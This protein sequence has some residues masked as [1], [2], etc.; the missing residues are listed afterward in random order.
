MAS[1]LYKKDLDAFLAQLKGSQAVYG[2]VH[3]EGLIKFDRVQAG[4]RLILDYETTATSAKGLF[5]P[6]GEQLFEYSGKKISKPEPSD[7]FIVFMNAID[8]EAVSILD[9][10]FG[11]RYKD[12]AYLAR[13][14]KSTIIAVR[15][16]VTM[17]NSFDHELPL[18]FRDGFDLMFTDEGDR[19]SLTAR[20]AKGRRLLKY[21]GTGKA[22]PA[23]SQ[24]KADKM[25]LKRISSFLERGPNHKLWEGLAKECFACGIC[26]YVCPVCHCFDVEDSSKLV[27]GGSRCRNWDSCMLSDF[28]AVAGGGNFR[29]KRHERIHNW[30]HHK[31]ARALAERGRP[32]CVGCGRCI[33]YCP[34][35]IR[36]YEKIRE[37]GL[38]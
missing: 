28:A 8:A 12:T 36:I 20:T 4:D 18:R 35:K 19:Y 17:L 24:P 32:D 22:V 11:G 16:N 9:E 14:G 33:T 37:C 1:V 29:G 3:R 15:N 7:A 27:G 23:A 25:D 26:A 38:S 31:F 10:A 13:R 6:H 5:F 21:A 30:Y 2:P 34:A